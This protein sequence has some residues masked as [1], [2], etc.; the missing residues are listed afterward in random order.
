MSNMADQTIDELAS[1]F[2][3]SQIST[4]DIAS[5]FGGTRVQPE[6]PW[7]RVAASGVLNLPRSTYQLG[8]DLVTAVMNPIDTARTA[9]DLG[10][11]ALRSILPES[12]VSNID[13]LEEYIQGSTANA[14]RAVTVAEN[15]GNFYINKYG[16]V[17]GAKRAIAQDPA[18]IAADIATIF[19]V[20]ATVAPAK[21]SG[22]LSRIAATVEP[23]SA[24]T[25][26][27]SRAAPAVSGLLTGT[28]PKSLETAFGSGRR[29]GDVGNMFTMA[30][31]NP[32]FISETVDI[33]KRN[34]QAL[35]NQRG[36]Q[37]R[38]SMQSIKDD[39]SILSLDEVSKKI[40]EARERTRFEG[41]V[42][43][44][45]ADLALDKMEDIVNAWKLLDPEIYH[46][47]I[48]LDALK[49]KLYAEVAQTLSYTDN[50]NARSIANS[51]VREI[52][53]TISSQA[54][55]YATFMKNYQEAS[56]LIQ[57]IEK[58]LS[59]NP[60]ASVD[61]SLRK[62]S[63]LMR[64]NVN[65]NYGERLRLAEALEKGGT[66]FMPALAGQTLSSFT[67]RGFGTVTT[68]TIAGPSIATGYAAANPF[69]FGGLLGASSPRLMGELYYGA[70]RAYGAIPRTFE[71]LQGISPLRAAGEYANALYNPQTAN[72]LYQLERT[73]DQ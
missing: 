52:G 71:S 59:L 1:Q 40:T 32:G 11:G 42:K 58:T 36:E 16:S 9:L 2:G 12:I 37:Y 34:L 55:T 47:A 15:V 53:D 31:R 20:G 43:D 61:T 25:S 57:E 50:A 21:L 27:I 3:G 68:G 72:L 7:S 38:Q 22:Q 6:M 56:E 17:E 29:G 49:Q 44:A 63:S 62:L 67:P 26:G 46:N 19:G 5:E 60:N 70:G 30:M 64:N 39:P 51:V 13:K 41:V 35:R 69:L 45:S 14:E 66:E 8:K 48:G 28:G 18:G 54:P 24:V 65:T 23:L 73:Q 33:A 4:Q 10:G